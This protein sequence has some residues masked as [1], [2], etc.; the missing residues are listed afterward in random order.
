MHGHEEQ[1]VKKRSLKPTKWSG[2]AKKRILKGDKTKLQIVNILRHSELSL[3]FVIILL[4]TG[5][6]KETRSGNCAT[7][8]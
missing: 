5:F 8:I 3:I 4:Q 7:M 6:S 1:R 2:V